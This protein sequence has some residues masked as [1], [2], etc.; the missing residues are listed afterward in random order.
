MGI[1]LKAGGRVR[2]PGRQTIKTEN[3]YIRLLCKLYSFLARRTDSSFNAT[4]LKRLQ[5]SRRNRPT[6]SLSKLARHMQGKE[7]KIAVVVGTIT[8]DARLFEVPQLT[9]CALRFSETARARIVKAGGSCM[10]FDQ[11]A[12]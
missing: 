3:P 2:K 10:T 6:L 7:D 9:V 11:L 1:D 8:D 12:L 5:T 4:I